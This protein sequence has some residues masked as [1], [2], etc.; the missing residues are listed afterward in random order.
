[1]PGEEIFDSIRLRSDSVDFTQW[2]KL[3]C[4]DANQLDLDVS[5][6]R[7]DADRSLQFQGNGQIRTGG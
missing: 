7:L 2:P 6:L 5:D 4:G 3:S 1:M